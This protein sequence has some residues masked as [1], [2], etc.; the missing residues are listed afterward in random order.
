MSI[1]N[2]IR[3]IDDQEWRQHPVFKNIECSEL[4]LIRINGNIIKGCLTDKLYRVI[5]IN[6]KNV[7]AHRI[8]YEC[9]FGLIPEGLVVDHINTLKWDNRP[10]NLR[11]VTTV[12]N[13]KNPLT[14]EHQKNRRGHYVLVKNKIDGKIEGWYPSKKA[15]AR[16]FN[17]DF[18]HIRRLL[19]RQYTNKHIDYGCVFEETD[20]KYCCKWGKWWLC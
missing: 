10:E 4:G 2:A 9:F 17:T 20:E 6:G 18:T 3:K 7:Y 12:E 8:I 11:A 5:H 19:Q 1:S 15:C 13:N 14:I 16:A